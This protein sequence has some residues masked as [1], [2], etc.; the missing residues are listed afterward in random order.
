MPLLLAGLILSGAGLALV[1]AQPPGLPDDPGTISNTI[2]DTC[3]S[4]NLDK[5]QS[6]YLK[7]RE[8]SST[9]EC[10]KYLADMYYYRL[11]RLQCSCTGTCMICNGQCDNTTVQS[12]YLR[13]RVANEKFHRL[14]TEG[15]CSSI[16]LGDGYTDAGG[17]STT[18]SLDA[19]TTSSPAVPPMATPNSPPKFISKG[20][21]PSS[22]GDRMYTYTLSLEDPDG[23]TVTV[24]LC[25][26]VVNYGWECFDS[27][28]VS[29]RGYAYWNMDFS[30]ADPGA[31]RY[32]FVYD[33]GEG[34]RGAW[35]PFDGPVI[36][37]STASASTT[38]AD[39]N[40]SGVS[41]SV[42]GAVGI[43]IAT[44][45]GVAIAKKA[46]GRGKSRG[47]SGEDRGDDS[48]HRTDFDRFAEAVEDSNKGWAPKTKQ[49]TDL[50]SQSGSYASK[51]KLHVKVGKGADKAVEKA[52]RGKRAK[53]VKDLRELRKGRS[54]SKIAKGKEYER[55]RELVDEWRDILKGKGG[56]KWTRLTEIQAEAGGIRKLWWA[57]KYVRLRNLA[58]RA[59]RTS[60]TYKWLKSMSKGLSK[61]TRAVSNA[62]KKFVGAASV[63]LQVY[64][65]TTSYNRYVSQ[66]KWFIEENPTIGRILGAT[67][68][69][70]EQVIIYTVTKNPVIG[71]ADAALSMGTGG[72]ISISRGIQE[73]EGLIDR[74][75]RAAFDKY[76]EGK[77]SDYSKGIVNHDSVKS[78]LRKLNDPEYVKRL[79][80]RGWSDERIERVRK[81]MREMLAHE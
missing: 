63:G 79:K 38:D 49:W 43:G 50:V 71:L 3:S 53:L 68:A 41:D 9:S 25:I 20:L 5:L 14:L 44:A 31:Y 66:N 30:G 26:E 51:Q 29:G 21:N 76:F 23:D 15:K 34:H 40:D 17:A 48:D 65:G 55:A 42:A 61:A 54:I 2:P 57:E 11:L 24:Q 80:E 59:A 35:G 69:V 12:F 75:S 13:E 52:F 37:S 32:K 22:Q 46:R 70:G 7:A 62:A 19:S 56:K 78:H 64:D 47:K 33:D 74:G 39:G 28:Q 58:K 10:H 6:A 73:V 60:K 27:Y 1:R 45:T 81:S 8:L 16:D 67:K 4:E 18:S 36:S 77:Y 72:R